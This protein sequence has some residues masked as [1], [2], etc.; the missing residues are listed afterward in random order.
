MV[1]RR[2]FAYWQDKCG[3]SD[4]KFTPERR[5]KVEARIKEGYTEQQVRQAI[6]GAARAAFVN[7]VGKRF[8]D[9]ELICRN[10]S[11]LEDF[12]GRVSA[13]PK[14]QASSADIA[15]ALNRNSAA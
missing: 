14:S 3:H 13:Q 4:A 10:G 2:L 6:D 8:D 1:A 7:D 15:A 12:L 5:R 9:I 11:K